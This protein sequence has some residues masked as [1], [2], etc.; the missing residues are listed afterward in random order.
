MG[1]DRVGDEISGGRGHAPT[2]G[3]ALLVVY[4]TALPSLFSRPFPPPPPFLFPLSTLFNT[5]SPNLFFPSF[6]ACEP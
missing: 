4:R 5:L 1:W 2:C 6:F 3:G